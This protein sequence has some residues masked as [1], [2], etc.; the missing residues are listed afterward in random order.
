MVEAGSRIHAAAR[1][2]DDATIRRNSHAHTMTA[3]NSST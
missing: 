2:V 1:A 3:L